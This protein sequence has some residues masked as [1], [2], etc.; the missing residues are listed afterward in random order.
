MYVYVR[1]VSST[2]YTDLAQPS[3]V[4]KVGLRFKE[5]NK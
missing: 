4:L 1:D 2:G 3:L 5:K